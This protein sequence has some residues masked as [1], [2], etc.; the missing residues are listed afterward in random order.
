MDPLDFGHRIS[1]EKD[2][3]NATAASFASFLSRPTSSS[4][5]PPSSSAPSGYRPPPSNA[6][7]DESS[8]F[9]IFPSLSGIKIFNVEDA[10]GNDMSY[11]SPEAVAARPSSLLSPPAA[12]IIGGVENTERF[13]SL[14]LYQGVPTM[15]SQFT[16]SKDGAGTS[17]ALAPPTLIMS[18]EAAAASKGGGSGGAPAPP[19]SRLDPAIFCTSLRRNRFYIFSRREPGELRSASSSIDGMGGG[20]AASSVGRDVFNE[21]PSKEDLAVAAE[22]SAAV[23]RVK[24]GNEATI[25]TS[26]GDIVVKL[27]PPNAPKAVENFCGHSRAKYYDGV[28]FHRY[29][30]AREGIESVYERVLGDKEA[31]SPLSKQMLT[32]GDTLAVHNSPPTLRSPPHPHPPLVNAE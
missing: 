7:W 19:I 17:A 30:R 31:L 10:R 11:A 29:V 28:I 27:F 20:A 24:L 13:L 12:A 3:A 2:L 14:S 4:K 16:L 22:T 1:L 6:I 32:A 21:P 26:L 23:A 18:E 8:N 9:I 5:P 15:S 25:H